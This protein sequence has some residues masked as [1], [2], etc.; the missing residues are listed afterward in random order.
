MGGK[1]AE[2]KHQFCPGSNTITG[3]D[4]AMSARN[5]IGVIQNQSWVN[6]DEWGRH[7]ST[8]VK[9]MCLKYSN[10]T[11]NSSCS[12]GGINSIHSNNHIETS[13]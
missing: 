5:N 7:F 10:Y 9:N 3:Q 12:Y 4:T 6:V 8:A 13:T 11:L 2:S 1:I